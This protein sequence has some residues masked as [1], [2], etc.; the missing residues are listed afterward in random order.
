MKADR[1]IRR[2]TGI[3]PAD[4]NFQTLGRM[5]GVSTGWKPVLL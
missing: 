2:S 4:Y 3:L 1:T 5:P